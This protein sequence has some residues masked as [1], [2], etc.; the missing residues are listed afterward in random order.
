MCS[1]RL[2]GLA[3]QSGIQCRHRSSN[4]A[5]IA[6]GVGFVQGFRRIN[7]SAVAG[8]QRG[9][10]G[11]TLSA[12]ALERFIQGCAEHFPQFLFCFTVQRHSLGF[13]LPALL[14]GFDRVHAQS[15]CG[16]QF[17]GFIDQGLTALDAGFLGC[18]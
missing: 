14:Q 17:S 16:T 4:L 1:L 5:G 3:T 10:R 2:L 7:H 8:S 9:R 12:F 18:L 13:D 6:R 11:M 15:G